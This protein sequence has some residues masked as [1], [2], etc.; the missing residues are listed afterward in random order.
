MNINDDIRQLHDTSRSRLAKLKQYRE[1]VKF[2]AE[3][4]VRRTN[5]LLQYLDAAI[6]EEERTIAPLVATAKGQIAE[7][8]KEE[9]ESINGKP[10][11][12]KKVEEKKRKVIKD[13]KGIEYIDAAG[14]SLEILESSEIVNGVPV[15]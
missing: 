8:S 2:N 4:F 13:E 11:E 6:I 5:N 7:A 1:N 12:E 3:L 9:I 10:V 14:N 15:K